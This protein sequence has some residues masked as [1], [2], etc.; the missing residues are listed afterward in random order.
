MRNARAGGDAEP[1]VLRGASRGARRGGVAGA[2][3]AV[4]G[5]CAGAGG[6]EGQRCSPGVWFFVGENTPPVPGRVKVD[7][8][9]IVVFKVFFWE[10]KHPLAEHPLCAVPS[11]GVGSPPGRC[12]TGRGRGQKPAGGAYGV[13]NPGFNVSEARA[14]CSMSGEE[15]G[16]WPPPPCAKSTLICTLGEGQTRIFH[17][18][19]NSIL[20]NLHEDHPA[21]PGLGRERGCSYP[22]IREKEA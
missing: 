1:R 13:A 22:L 18:S 15:G 3:L 8:S 20:W 6:T 5:V 16:V 17:P 7:P 2:A 10:H 4:E 11:L 12:R 14:G 21:R 9:A 19:H